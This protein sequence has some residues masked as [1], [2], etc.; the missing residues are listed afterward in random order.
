MELVPLGKEW[1][2]TLDEAVQLTQLKLAECGVP[3]A[4]ID[5]TCAASSTCCW[6]ASHEKMPQTSERRGHLSRRAQLSGGRRFNLS[7]QL[8]S[9][10]RWW[11]WLVVSA[12]PCSR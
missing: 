4:R 11:R 12:P 9:Q 10:L 3:Q 1:F 6:R 5:I 7:S 2:G 8:T